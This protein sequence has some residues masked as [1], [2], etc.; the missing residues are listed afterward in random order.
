MKLFVLE[1]ESSCMLSITMIHRIIMMI[2]SIYAIQVNKIW[3]KVDLKIQIQ[4]M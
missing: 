1:M 4:T 3:S 2:N